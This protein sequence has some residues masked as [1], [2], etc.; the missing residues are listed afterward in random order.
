MRSEDFRQPSESISDD[1]TP[2][3][4][5]TQPTQWNYSRGIWLL[6]AIFVFSWLIV[7]ATEVMGVILAYLILAFIIAIVVAIPVAIVYLLRKPR[8]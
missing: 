4:H 3:V 6:I 5:R 1:V 7:N 8:Q 2:E